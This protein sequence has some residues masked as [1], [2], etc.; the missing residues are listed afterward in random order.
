MEDIDFWVNFVSGNSNKL[1]QL[2]LEGKISWVLNVFTLPN[3]EV[4]KSENVK[5]K[6]CVHTW[7][8]KTIYTSSYKWN[9]YFT[10]YDQ[11]KQ[12]QT[13]K[14]SNPI[15]L[16]IKKNFKPMQNPILL[17][18]ENNDPFLAFSLVL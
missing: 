10:Q 13:T 18:I 16:K 15:D 9:S 2:G 4:F 1:Q 3:L 5:N 12:I 17:N 8:N 14:S 11:N 7:A 6:E